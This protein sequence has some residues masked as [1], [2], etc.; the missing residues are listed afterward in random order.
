[1]SVS[2]SSLSTYC[3][4]SKKEL[5]AKAVAGANTFA[6]TAFVNIVPGIPYGSQIQQ[7]FFSVIPGYQVNSTC[8]AISGS[9]TFT[10][11]LLSTSLVVVSD[12]WCSDDLRAKLTPYMPAGANNA[13]AFEVPNEVI[14]DIT[15]QMARD[16]A[17]TA[18]Q[19]MRGAP[20]N[21]MN[22]QIKGWLYRLINNGASSYSGSTFKTTSTYTSL[23]SSNFI[24]AMDDFMANVPAAI[25]GMDLVIACPYDAYNAGKVAYRNTYGAGS[26]EVV[27]GD[28][29]MYKLL[30]YDN[31]TVKRDDGLNGAKVCVMS[32]A[33]GG[34]FIYNVDIAGDATEV[35]VGYD[36]LTDKTW[37]RLKAAI[38]TEIK[39]AEEVG[40]LN[41]NTG[42]LAN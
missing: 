12:A 1:M 4:Q 25:Q 38:G 34:N 29:E 35:K 31:V 19:G 28:V 39:F 14:D 42:S 7:K 8:P 22:G 2:T 16:A 5:L 18:W 11:K 27:P 3:D 10:E 40:V 20:T 17:V 6:D 23:T 30:G 9:T 32:T 26:L 21:S 15:A 24:A 33:K 13:E 41:Y 37:Y 36:G